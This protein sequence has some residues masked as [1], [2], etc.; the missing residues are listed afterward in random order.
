MLPILPTETHF[1][2]SFFTLFPKNLHFSQK[3][4]MLLIL[5]TETH[6]YRSFFTLFPK[7]LHFSQ[8]IYILPILPSDNNT[9][10]FYKVILY[11]CVLHWKLCTARRTFL[12][13]NLDYDIIKSHSNLKSIHSHL[14]LTGRNPF[15]A[16]FIPST[17][18]KTK[19]GNLVPV[20][21]QNKGL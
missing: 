17:F 3:L 15:R 18:S 13:T 1:Y 5:P 20:F 7:K 12:T 8:K 19:H 2:R 4:S 9:L 6:F 11:T 16:C 21:T 10:P 14:A